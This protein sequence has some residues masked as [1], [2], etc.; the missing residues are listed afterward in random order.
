[1]AVPR[2]FES[3]ISYEVNNVLHLDNKGFL[4]LHFIHQLAIVY[5]VGRKGPS[6]SLVSLWLVP[7]LG[8][9]HFVLQL[10]L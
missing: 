8:L 9:T 6:T 1:M 2:P 10:Y 7:K 3:W 5:I 4:V